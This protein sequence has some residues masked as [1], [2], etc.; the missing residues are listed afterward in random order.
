MKNSEER[1][2]EAPYKRFAFNMPEFS[3]S[4]ADLGTL[5]PLAI[6]MIV[7]IGLDPTGVF[8]MVGAVYLLCG[9]YYG[10][11]MPVQPMKMIGAYAIAMG[12]AAGTVAAS[13]LL[14]GLFMLFIGVTGAIQFVGKYIPTSVIRGIQGTVGVLLAAEG[15]KF[16]LGATRFQ[17]VMVEPHL[18]LQAIGPIPI[19]L[20]L[21]V[22]A[23]GIVFLLLENK[24]IPA[25]L[26]VIVGGMLVGAFMGT[27]EG[28]DKIELFHL[29]QILPLGM[30]SLDMM[31]VAL[32]ALTLPQIPL[33]IGNAVIASTDMAKRYF[34]DNA[35]RVNYKSISISMGLGNIAA[36]TVGGMPMCHGAGG[37]AAHYRFGSRTA[38]T[39]VIIGAIFLVLALLFGEH[40]LAILYLLPF[41]FLGALLIFAGVEL[42]LMILDVKKRTD[43]FVALTMI[44]TTLATNLAIAFAV[45]LILAYAFK[46]E[47]FKI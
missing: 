43:L 46:T 35:K 6:G 32:T 9:L 15:I 12:F 25:A 26:V 45:G 37:L 22:I 34:G 30:P 13:G 40:A 36:F 29:P 21:G 18:I 28:M 1:V 23:V 27:H 5:L 24:R 8:F 17:E 3:G 19:S 10:V 44:A 14:I 16:I 33:T 47:K 7:V 31:V 38:G 20:I 11:T 4:L 41:S 2:S 42:A 39:N